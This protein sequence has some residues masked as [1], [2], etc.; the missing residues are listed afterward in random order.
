MGCSSDVS[1][2]SFSCFHTLRARQSLLCLRGSHRFVMWSYL[3]HLYKRDAD[4]PFAHY[5]WAPIVCTTAPMRR[6]SR[7]S[8]SS[9]S[10]DTEVTISLD[11]A[12]LERSY[13]YFLLSLGFSRRF[14]PPSFRHPMVS[15]LMG[16]LPRFHIWLMPAYNTWGLYEFA[17]DGMK[18]SFHC[19]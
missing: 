4:D 12:G 7:S 2:V 18:D 17:A 8:Q 5:S 14:F 6:P 19:Y 10:I 13:R 16:I 3:M 1:S 15:F 9:C 11:E